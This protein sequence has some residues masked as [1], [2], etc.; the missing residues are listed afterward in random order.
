MEIVREQRESKWTEKEKKRNGKDER[1]CKSRGK[2]Y[3]S[4]KNNGLPNSSQL[5]RCRNRTH[6]GL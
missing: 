4:G 5:T 3:K 6:K 2:A 1:S